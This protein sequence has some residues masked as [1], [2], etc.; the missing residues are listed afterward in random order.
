MTV[1]KTRN[2]E[3]GAL[4]KPEDI[5]ASAWNDRNWEQA[6]YGA[7][8]AHAQAGCLLCV[9]VLAVFTGDCACMMEL[10]AEVPQLLLDKVTWKSEVTISLL[11]DDFRSNKDLITYR[12]TIRSFRL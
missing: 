1:E 11:I 4:V 7:K 3:T 9:V 12:G 10:S 2:C 8:K 5:I 6:W